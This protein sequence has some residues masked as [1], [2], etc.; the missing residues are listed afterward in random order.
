MLQLGPRGLQEA[1]RARTESTQDYGTRWEG[2]GKGYTGKLKCDVLEPKESLPPEEGAGYFF[3]NKH[4]AIHS[5]W[6]ASHQ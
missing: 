1:W 5:W 2:Q 6:H 4:A 3:E